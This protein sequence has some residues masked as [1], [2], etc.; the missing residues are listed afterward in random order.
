MDGSARVSWTP[1]KILAGLAIV[2][3]LFFARSVLIPVAVALLISLLLG[4]MVQGLE[5]F[6]IP[7]VAAVLIVV[8]LALAVLGWMGFVVTSQVS[9]L[10]GQLPQYKDRIRVKASSIGEPLGGVLGKAYDA[11]Q[12]I[13]KP[14][15]PGGPKDARPA[16]EVVPV[17]IVETPPTPW[18]VISYLLSSVIRTLGAFVLVT[19]LVVFL[20][21]FHADLR[22]RAV[23][24]FGVHR[25]NI[26]T[27]TINEAATTV[28]RYLLSQSAVN[29]VYGL[30]IGTTLAAL[31]VPN[32][33]LWG[34]L[35]A[36]LRFIPYAGPWIG[37]APPF[38]LTLAVYD[39]W[40]RPLAFAVVVLCLEIAIANVLEPL[41]YG[42]RA[43]LS[44]LALIIAAVFWTWLWGNSGLLLSVP[45]TVCLE[46]LGRHVPS[47]GFLSTL[48]ARRTVVEPHV[49]FYQR[50]LA[51]RP[52][53]AS[54]LVEA[55]LRRSSIGDVCDELLLPALVLAEHDLQRGALERDEHAAV[56]QG[57]EQVLEDLE[58][59]PVA[60]AEPSIR[61]CC[62][63]ASGRGDELACRMLARVLADLKISLEI[64]P[65]SAMTA[66]KVER[67]ERQPADLA[68]ISTLDAS[69]RL[70][71]WHFY[72]R[73]RR[74]LPELPLLAGVWG[75]GEDPDST[76]LRLQGESKVRTVHRFSE[77]RTQIE[78]LIPELRLRKRAASAT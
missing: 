15:A 13:G 6:R 3:A 68:C 67:V 4:P 48:L 51:M 66:E 63:P 26:T 74:R 20:L 60:P 50:L 41:L 21:I 55:R 78:Q 62:V 40:S 31:G 75:A 42:R 44:P 24:L 23:L 37:F 58:E 5:R 56:L 19:I 10:A 70:Q 30:L 59:E 73:L 9:D 43:G 17:Q 27:Q 57:M 1:L 16:R 54:A 77:A 25:I 49:R 11:L 65:A 2:G 76:A 52:T 34:C 71:A 46:V 33:V 32:F 36:V 29:A 53:D 61:L 7:R 8:A 39:G 14:S 38:L 45:L 69:G 72:K 47:L 22:D 12:D 64:V 18:E 28:S 35:A